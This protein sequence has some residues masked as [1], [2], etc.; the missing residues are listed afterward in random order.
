MSAH[1]R[2]TKKATILH[3]YAVQVPD[4]LASRCRAFFFCKKKGRLYIVNRGKIKQPACEACFLQPGSLSRVAS[5]PGSRN[6]PGQPKT[7]CAD[8]AR[9]AGTYRV[10][11]PCEMCPE[12]N[13]LSSSQ[14]NAAGQPRKLC[15]KHARG[16][17]TH[18]VLNP[19]EMCP[20]DNKL[21]AHYPNASGQPNRLCA[22]HEGGRNLPGP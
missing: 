6:A 11:N 13:Q 8:H 10:Q 5:Y 4:V 9:E 21:H 20:E 7:L 19:C 16:E 18:H 1:H 17:G 2:V 15:A 14:P 3:R 22:D 12:D